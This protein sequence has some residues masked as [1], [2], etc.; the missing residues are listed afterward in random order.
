MSDYKY[1]NLYLLCFFLSKII[2]FLISYTVHIWY[3]YGKCHSSKCMLT[4]SDVYESDKRIR[5]LL[6]ELIYEYVPFVVH[7]FMFMFYILQRIDLHVG[8]RKIFLPKK[9]TRIIYAYFGSVRTKRDENIDW[10]MRYQRVNTV[11]RTIKRLTR[12]SNIISHSE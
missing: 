3:I 1:Y 10:S 6:I 9:K 11:L 4:F 5:T 2:S 7:Y 12:V 8:L